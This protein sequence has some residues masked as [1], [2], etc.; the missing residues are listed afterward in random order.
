MG[1]QFVVFE[2]EVAHLALQFLLDVQSFSKFLVAVVE[3][4]L[5][6]LLP[7]GLDLG[8]LFI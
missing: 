8:V 7:L 2:V 3:L 4:E 6:S 5:S 1:V